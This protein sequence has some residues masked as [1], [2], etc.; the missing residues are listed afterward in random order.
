M[1][2]FTILVCFSVISS[3]SAQIGGNYAFPILDMAFNA[4]SNSLGTDFITA[5]D[6]DVNLGVSNP[7]LYNPEMHNQASFSHGIMPN[8]L[9]F[10]MASYGRKF[11]EKFNSAAHIR[12]VSYGV[13]DRM[14]ELG[15]NTGRF[16]PSDYII[17]AGTSYNL[18]PKMQIGANFNFLLS[19]L[20]R[21]VALGAA[22]DLAASYYEKKANL[23]LTI[24]AKNI[25]YQLKNYTKTERSNLPMDL[26]FGISHRLK[27]APFR[28]SMVIHHLNKWNLSYFDPNKKPTYD[29]LTNDTIYPK[30]DGFGRKLA[31]HFTF[32]SE[33]ILG[34]IIH[35]RAAFDIY[36]RSTLKVVNRP[37]LAGFSFGLGLY[38]KRFSIDYGISFY[39]VAG[40]QNMFT[41]STNIDRWKKQS[42]SSLR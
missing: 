41:L 34:K 1:R 29:P 37:G 40:M 16:H 21:Y 26:Q 35:V 7:S 11:G 31:Q 18:N 9:N 4:R 14:D 8:G 38:F 32:Q 5:I 23:M 12:Y 39:S 10:G 17:G 42:S 19:Q 6:Q 33:I 22:V 24:V 30:P 15:L 13:Q 36:R 27:H 2:F 3:A 20:D 28:F 25:G